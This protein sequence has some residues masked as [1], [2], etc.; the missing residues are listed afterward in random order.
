MT[1]PLVDIDAVP[2]CE[3]LLD[4]R[5][6]FESVHVFATPV[7]TRMTFV[8]KQGRCVGPRI[9]ADVLPGGG[10]WLLLGS[11]GVA[12]LD[13]RATLRTDDGALIH[14]ANTGR[15][16]MNRSATDR[17]TAGELI[18]H[19]EMTARSSPL[20][21]TDDERYRWLNAVHTVAINQVSLSEVH[22]R[23]FAVR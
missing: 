13:V 6:D 1:T 5:I 19:D 11:D 15:V 10:D 22:Y 12:R 20:F 2:I 16:R 21:E 9:A 14:L 8:V 3:H 23:V 18:R 17:F 4:I 7:G